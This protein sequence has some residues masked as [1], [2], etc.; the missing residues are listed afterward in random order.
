MGQAKP[1]PKQIPP[2]AGRRSPEGE[3]AEIV[4]NAAVARGEEAPAALRAIVDNHIRTYPK[5]I[6]HA[7]P[8]D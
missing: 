4:Y 2:Y 7:H 1:F 5:G 8:R 3:H 6:N